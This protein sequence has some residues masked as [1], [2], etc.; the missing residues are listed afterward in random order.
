MIE[1]SFGLM[2]MDVLKFLE[3]GHGQLY[4]E[5]WQLEQHPG[6]WVMMSALGGSR[7]VSRYLQPQH[8]Q[9]LYDRF[10]QANPSGVRFGE[11]EMMEEEYARQL[12]LTPA[13][14]DHVYGDTDLFKDLTGNDEHLG[15]PHLKP[16]LPEIYKPETIRAME[17]DPWLDDVLLGKAIHEGHVQDSREQHPRW[18]PEWRAYCDRLGGRFPEGWK[19]VPG[20]DSG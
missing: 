20:G 2:G 18:S 3:V 5:R 15:Y 12:G 10:R 4:M 1:Y 9:L 19:N 16:F 14:L 8:L 6:P 7:L 13:Q 11:T 17:A